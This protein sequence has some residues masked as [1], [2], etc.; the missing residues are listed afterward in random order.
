MYVLSRFIACCIVYIAV[1]MPVHAVDFTPNMPCKGVT[2]G[3]PCKPTPTDE[4]EKREGECSITIAAP[5]GG[6]KEAESLTVRIPYLYVK[7]FDSGGTFFACRSKNGVTEF[8]DIPYN[9]FT[10]IGAGGR[11][12][13]C[14]VPDASIDGLKKLDLF[15]RKKKEDRGDQEYE[16]AKKILENAAKKQSVALVVNCRKFFGKYALASYTKTQD[17]EE[18]QQALADVQARM[19][20]LGCVETK[21]S[22]FGSESATYIKRGDCETYK[23]T[24]DVTKSRIDT[25][26]Q[27]LAREKRTEDASVRH[28]C[29]TVPVDAS[30]AEKD[31]ISCQRV[32]DICA[33]V[34]KAA[35]EA[36]RKTC[37]ST[38]DKKPPA[39]L[40]AEDKAL[41]EKSDGIAGDSQSPCYCLGSKKYDTKT[42]QCIGPGATFTP[43]KKRV[44]KKGETAPDCASPQECAVTDTKVQHCAQ[45][46]KMYSEQTCGCVSRQP[47]PPDGPGYPGP[48]R[49]VSSY[50]GAA[51]CMRAYDEAFAAERSRAQNNSGVFGNITSFFSGSSSNTYVPPGCEDSARAGRESGQRYA[52]SVAQQ[53]ARQQALQRAQ[54]QAQQAQQAQQS[55]QQAAQ[56]ASQVPQL[57]C[58]GVKVDKDTIA[59]GQQ[60]L[61]R[62][63]IPNATQFELRGGPGTVSAAG[64]TVRPKETTTYYI[65]GTNPQMIQ[66]V[67]N[68]AAY[69]QQAQQY[70]TYDMA[71]YVNP[72]YGQS[73]TDSSVT[74]QGVSTE[75]NGV[76]GPGR[77]MCGPITITVQADA[78]QSSSKTDDASLNTELTNAQKKAFSSSKPTLR[79]PTSVAPGG[80]ANILWSC[81]DDPANPDG[82]VVAVAAAVHLDG[83][84]LTDAER[85]MVRADGSLLKELPSDGAKRVYPDSDIQ[86]GVVCKNAARVRTATAKCVVTVGT[87]ARTTQST[88]ATR[89]SSVSSGSLAAPAGTVS[90]TA[91]PLTISVRKQ[92]QTTVQWRAPAEYSCSVHGPSGYTSTLSNGAVSGTSNEVGELTFTLVCNEGSANEIQKQVT[93]QAID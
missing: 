25:I 67:Q 15:L 66:A 11:I 4:G 83:T 29:F 49:E 20:S 57:T 55:A 41:C 31:T 7:L 16:G 47:T 30:K 32:A 75:T 61:I 86:Y 71:N 58:A 72:N 77:G 59:P 92:Q 63:S 54:Q 23:Q 5:A 40:S 80:A 73:Y 10:Y 35:A 87:R 48:G 64:A 82:Q 36:L 28:T 24:E 38:A 13:A 74:A 6:G 17:L 34:D 43:D 69:A 85:I 84:P 56:Y 88:S 93:I 9:Q 52:Q 51:V 33:S 65:V 81:P 60:A 68:A 26:K 62:F 79:C 3:T 14:S 27:D 89:V 46:Q 91:T 70:S 1:V 76:V 78:A 22:W 12:N 37:G 42:K 21:K 2:Q 18:Q 50:P 45:Q 19:K 90:I 44:C 8:G 39:P 53:A